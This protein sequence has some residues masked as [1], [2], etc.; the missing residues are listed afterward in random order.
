MDIYFPT[1]PALI[2]IAFVVSIVLVV[3]GVFVDAKKG[4]TKNVLA[5]TFTGLV[6]FNALIAA[7]GSAALACYFFL[8]KWVFPYYGASLG[9]YP[10]AT[11]TQIV[12]TLGS[13]FFVAVVTYLVALFFF[14]R[15]QK[16][17]RESMVTYVYLYGALFLGL[18]MGLYGLIGGVRAVAIYYLNAGAVGN[19]HYDLALR[20]PMVG[21]GALVALLHVLQIIRTDRDAKDREDV[22]SA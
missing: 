21:I 7:M 8:G 6:G 15:R 17:S 18:L 3:A 22:H 19:L 14:G 11:S 1:V 10:V 12:I 2:G 5:T 16:E 4:N 13:V 20:L 9:L